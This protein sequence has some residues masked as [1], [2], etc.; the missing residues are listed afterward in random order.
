MNEKN[1]FI[2]LTVLFAFQFLCLYN[3]HGILDYGKNLESSNFME[4]IFSKFDLH[5]FTRPLGVFFVNTKN[6]KD[7]ATA[8][9]WLLYRIKK[10]KA[11]LNYHQ[12]QAR[13]IF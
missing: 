4:E 1:Y 7:I 6:T 5:S 2:L 9:E 8:F 12:K 13:R 10:D 11:E 3:D